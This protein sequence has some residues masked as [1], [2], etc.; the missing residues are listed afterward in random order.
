MKVPQRVYEIIVELYNRNT[1]L[2]RGSDN[3]RRSLTMIMAEQVRFELGP[4]WGTKRADKGRPL[5]KDS[6]SF[7]K[8]GILMNYDWQNGST[9]APHNPPGNMKDISNQEFV[10]VDSI[11][12]LGTLGKPPV[13]VPPPEPFN[14]PKG[15]REYDESLSVEFGM[16]CNR[17]YEESH[18][19][20]DAGMIAVH[21]GRATYDYYVLRL[22]WE[23]SKKK[24][25][26]NF[27]R[28]YG[29]GAI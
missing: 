1:T 18:K 17:I 13:I 3:D 16:A 4:N 23:E 6:I 12:H 26:N 5:G 7:Y 29:L 14:P 20:F 19:P 27:R 24:H 2:A 25:I 11:D 9:R 15:N 10:V 22:P 8:D 21:T 28:E